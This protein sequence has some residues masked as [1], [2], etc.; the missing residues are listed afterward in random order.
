MIAHFYVEVNGFRYQFRLSPVGRGRTDSCGRRRLESEPTKGVGCGRGPPRRLK[1][2]L[3]SLTRAS[4]GRCPAEKQFAFTLILRQPGCPFEFETCL[5][6]TAELDQQI[7]AYARQQVIASSDGSASSLSTTSP[8]PPP[9]RSH[10]EGDR[11]VQ[12]D[13]R[14]EGAS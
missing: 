13:R 10:R 2:P 3:R 7:A 5:F 11:A 9:D 6:K 14:A 1:E 12:L 4:A 8:D